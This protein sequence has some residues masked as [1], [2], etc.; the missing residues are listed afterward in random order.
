MNNV[1]VYN[2]I[3]AVNEYITF[4]VEEQPVPTSFNRFNKRV[5]RGFTCVAALG[6]IRNYSRVERLNSFFTGMN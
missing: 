2:T 1:K 4:G 6:K 5:S 3:Y